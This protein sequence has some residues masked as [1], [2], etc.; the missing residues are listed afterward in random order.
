MALPT[1]DARLKSDP[2]KRCRKPV[3][4]GRNRCRLHGGLSTGP[5]TA[6]GMATGIAAMRA[7]YAPWLEAR[8]AA[9]LPTFGRPKGAKNISTRR[10]QAALAQ[11]QANAA[12]YDQD[13]DA[14]AEAVFDATMAKVKHVRVDDFLKYTAASAKREEA[15]STYPPLPPPPQRKD[16]R[17]LPKP[18]RVKRQ[19]PSRAQIAPVAETPLPAIAQ[20]PLP[21]QPAPPPP[22]TLEA[23]LTREGWTYDPAVQAWSRRAGPTPPPP[24]PVLKGWR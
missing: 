17:G 21:S 4:A 19:R 10:Y 12:S 13:R 6:E 5:R 11:W 7:G 1:C 18:R 14:Y 20:A 8:R 22:D 2:T 15:R 3:V 23:R 24:I 16:F 9:G